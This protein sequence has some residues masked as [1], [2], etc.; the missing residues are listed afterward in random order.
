MFKLVCFVCLLATALAA[1]SWREGA[2]ESDENLVDADS[3]E[4]NNPNIN[5]PAINSPCGHKRIVGGRRNDAVAPEDNASAMNSRC[6]GHPDND[7]NNND[8]NSTT[9]IEKHPYQVSLYQD[10]FYFASGSIISSQWVLTA[11]HWEIKATPQYTVRVGSSHRHT[12]FKYT[13]AE[14]KKHELYK[15]SSRPEFSDYDIAVIRINGRFTFGSNVQPIPLATRAPPTGALAVLVGW[16]RTVNVGSKLRAVSVP[17]VSQDKCRRFY[18]NREEGEVTPR[19]LCAGVLSGDFSTCAGD[20]GSPL[21]YNRAQRVKTAT[22]RREERSVSEEALL[23]AGSN[24]ASDPEDSETGIRARCGGQHPIANVR[25]NNETDLDPEENE[26]EMK[27]RN[28]GHQ[29][30]VGGVPTSIIYHPYQVSLQE[31]SQHFCGGSIIS[32]QWVL[33]AA[34]CRVQSTPPYTVRVGSSLKTKGGSIYPVVEVKRHELF[35]AF[36]DYDIAVVRPI[37][38]AMQ[39]PPPGGWAVVSGWGRTPSHEMLPAFPAFPAFVTIVGIVVEYVMLIFFCYKLQEARATNVISVASTLTTHC[40]HC[41]ETFLRIAGP[42]ERGSGGL[43]AGGAGQRGS[44]EP[45]GR[46]LGGGPGR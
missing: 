8:D 33:T 43:R 24:L 36:I 22:S 46:W 11:A 28:G 9:T 2:F 31:Y 4:A 1:N 42:F 35:N 29:R 25:P 12:G 26:I 30:I 32:P 13:V 23:D 16:G 39:E 20:D 15:K 6:G 45:G 14:V 38:L 34:H 7:D 17:I 5:A 27:A 19:M 44:L 41:G 10:T 37:P 40:S 21:V 3:Q 18:I